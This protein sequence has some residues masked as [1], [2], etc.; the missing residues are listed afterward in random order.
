MKRAYLY[1]GLG[2][3]AGL[4]AS[5]TL[6]WVEADNATLPARG[7]NVATELLAGAHYQLIV[8]MIGAVGSPAR[9]TSTAPV[10]IRPGIPTTM[11]DTAVAVAASSSGD[12]TIVSGTASQTIRL[13][14]A[15]LQ[16]VGASAVTIKWRTNT[17]D[18]GG[19][20]TL[21]PYQ[22]Y[23]LDPVGEPYHVTTSSQALNLNLSDAISVTGTVWYTKS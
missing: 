16:N 8:P 9:I 14:R 21:L 11:G 5:G 13:T 15:I 19:T 7:E 10:W 18:M 3:L 4:L 20:V 1:L 17:T 23:N 12:N 22:P 6:S 2:A